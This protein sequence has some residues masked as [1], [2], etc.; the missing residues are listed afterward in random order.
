MIGEPL[1][2]HTYSVHSLAYS[3]DGA[4][5]IS[6][7]Y[8]RTIGV[9]DAE[10]GQMV[11]EPLEGHTDIVYSVAYSPSGTHIVSGSLDQ[12]IRIWNV[13]KILPNRGLPEAQPEGSALGHPSPKPEQLIQGD[14]DAASSPHD[15]WNLGRDGWGVTRS[16]QRLV[17]VHHDLRA[18]LLRPQNTI[19]IGKRGWLRL[20]F[21]EARVG[22]AWHQGYMSMD[23]ASDVVM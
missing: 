3:P 1:N 22:E 5:I 6:C 14:D 8:D 7:S 4:H 23:S 19:V 17:W 9:W 21:S 18:S 12:T 10:S 11:G 20:D 15:D 2:G 16:S 13:R